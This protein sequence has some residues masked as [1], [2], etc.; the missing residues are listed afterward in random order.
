[1]TV[2]FSGQIYPCQKAV[3][4]GS[5]AI[6]YLT[7]GGTLQ[8]SGVNDWTA[9]SLEDGDWSLPDVTSEEQLRA[10]VDFLLAMGG[11]V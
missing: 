8:F 11:F 3:R 2:N 10:D 5:S 4:S 1:M 6:L 7:D 9:F